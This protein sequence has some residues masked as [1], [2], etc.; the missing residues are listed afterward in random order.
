M[1]LHFERY[2]SHHRATKMIISRIFKENMRTWTEAIKL[3]DKDKLHNVTNGDDR[4]IKVI[5]QQSF[6]DTKVISLPKLH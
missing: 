6:T 1:R 3:M 5:R 4:Q 2:F